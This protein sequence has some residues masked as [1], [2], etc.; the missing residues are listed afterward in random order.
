MQ[1]DAVSIEWE[2]ERAHLVLAGPRCNAIG[3]AMLASL[4]AALDVLE[5]R[6][7]TVLV[8]S[9]GDPTGF[10]QGDD[11]IE[12]HARFVGRDSALHRLVDR[13]LPSRRLDPLLDSLAVHAFLRRINAVLTRL[14]RLP[15]PVVCIVHGV[16]MGGGWELV[17]ACDLV[18]AEESARFGLPEL[19]LATLPAFGAVPRLERDLGTA[20]LRDLLLSGRTVSAKRLHA[21]GV[22]HQVVPRGKGPQAAE[23]L[24][25]RLAALDPDVVRHTKAFVKPT[26][27]GRLLEERL[28]VLALTRRAP[29]REALRRFAEA[30]P[31]PMSYL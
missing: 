11:L 23:G 15:C 25:R 2:E 14:E 22:L 3:Q 10:C 19:R 6:R 31:R 24:T 1:H 8:I 7:P 4:E 9:S 12:A 27:R 16:C 29:F 30:T 20:M 28:R 21:L 5:A 26:P 13:I 18:V 17:A